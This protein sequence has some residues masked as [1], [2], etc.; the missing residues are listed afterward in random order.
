MAAI[1]EMFERGF[2]KATRRGSL[3]Y[4]ISKQLADL[5]KEKRGQYVGSGDCA[6]RCFAA[7]EAA[8]T[9]H[10]HNS[11]A[12]PSIISCGSLA[13]PQSSGASGLTCCATAAAIYLADQSTDLRTLQHDLGHR[14][15]KHTAHYTR[16]AGHR[17][18]DCGGRGTQEVRGGN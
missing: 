14:D 9:W 16:V 11:P 2:G 3:T 7:S 18:E 4:G 10:R 1:K 13:R 15:P 5:F 6:S 8:V 17:F 12:R